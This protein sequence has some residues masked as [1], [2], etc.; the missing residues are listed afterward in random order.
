MPQQKSK[1]SKSRTRMRRAHD[2]LVK[3]EQTGCANCGGA[4]RPH[5]I[6]PSCGHYKGREV[7]AAKK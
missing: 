5:R 3:P 2:F 6:C 4:I 7:V 1:V